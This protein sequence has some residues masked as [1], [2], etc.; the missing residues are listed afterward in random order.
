M[1]SYIIKNGKKIKLDDDGKP[2][3]GSKL[4]PDVY[5]NMPPEPPLPNDDMLPPEPPLPNDEMLPPEPPLPSDEMLPPESPLPN[6][7]RLSPEKL[8]VNDKKPST[9]KE[10]TV[11]SSDNIQQINQKNYESEDD[12]PDES[13]IY[14]SNQQ[15]NKLDKNTNIGKQKPVKLEK[16]SSHAEKIAKTIGKHTL[17]EEMKE[18]R[19]NFYWNMAVKGDNWVKGND[20]KRDQ[21]MLLTDENIH[22]LASVAAKYRTEDNLVQ[23][24]QTIT[25]RYPHVKDSKIDKLC[26]GWENSF[27]KGGTNEY[28]ANFPLKRYEALRLRSIENTASKSDLKEKELLDPYYNAWNE[29]LTKFKNAAFMAQKQDVKNGLIDTPHSPQIKQVITKPDD[30]KF[31]KTYSRQQYQHDKM[32]ADKDGNFFE[33]LDSY[34]KGKHAMNNRMVPESVE[35]S[36]SKY[37]YSFDNMLRSSLYRIND[38]MVSTLKSMREEDAKPKAKNNHSAMMGLGGSFLQGAWQ[39][40]SGVGKFGLRTALFIPR[41]AFAKLFG[42]DP[43]LLGKALTGSGFN[44]SDYIMQ[45]VVQNEKESRKK[46]GPLVGSALPSRGRGPSL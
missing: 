36:L 1:A 43:T 42:H 31:D 3:D 39:C 4:K 46:L 41:Y 6:D 29:N 15:N 19:D 27:Q 2:I 13:D 8:T 37:S 38:K 14:Q 30:I 5:Q 11:I 26:A 21:P 20:A 16:V 34:Y 9:L 10:P 33:P 24:V 7:K 40:A 25:D 22:H 35:R 32:M 23:H 17:S 45:A 44:H 18:R 12:P 28:L